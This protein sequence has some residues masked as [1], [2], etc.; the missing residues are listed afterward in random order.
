MQ[1]QEGGTFLY[2]IFL[3]SRTHC[4]DGSEIRTD[5]K[6]FVTDIWLFQLLGLQARGFSVLPGILSEDNG[7][8]FIM[9]TLMPL[10]SY[11]QNRI[12]NLKL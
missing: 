7:R 10:F 6:T 8:V 3:L 11:I 5:G 2:H 9:P 12:E 1:K 4:S